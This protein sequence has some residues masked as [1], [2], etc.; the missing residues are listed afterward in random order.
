MKIPRDCSGAQLAKALKGI[1]YV[2]IR[3]TGS[4]LIL[5]TY[6]DGENHVTIPQHRFLKVGMIM[7]S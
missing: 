1:G 2:P 6:Q 7:A 4:H 5:T 3:Q